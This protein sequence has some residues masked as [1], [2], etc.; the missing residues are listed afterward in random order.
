MRFIQQSA[1]DILEH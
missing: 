1:D